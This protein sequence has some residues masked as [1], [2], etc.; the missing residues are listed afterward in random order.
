MSDSL[1]KRNRFLVAAV[2]LVLNALLLLTLPGGPTAQANAAPDLNVTLSDSP[3]P[4]AP[5]GIVTFLLS[6]SN[7]GNAAASGTVYMV[8]HLPPG[9]S[10]LGETFAVGAGWTCDMVMHWETDAFQAGSHEAL[11]CTRSGMAIGAAPTVSFGAT[12]QAGV[13]TSNNIV[14]ID[15][16]IATEGTHAESNEDADDPIEACS[17]EDSNP[18]SQEPDNYDC[19]PNT[20][21]TDLPNLELTQSGSSSSIPTGGTLTYTLPSRNVGTGTASGY[22]IDDFVSAGSTITAFTATDGADC[23]QISPGFSESPPWV[24]P[25]TILSGLFT[26]PAGCTD[27]VTLT[28]TVTAGPGAILNGALTDSTGVV[29]EANE[30]ADDPDLVCTTVGE[31]SDTAP[32]IEPDN[33]DCLQITV[34]AGY[35]WGDVDCVGDVDAV[36]ALKILRYVAGLS[37]SQTQPCP[38][39]GSEVASLLGDVDCDDDVDAIDSLKILRHVAALPVAQTEP[40]QDIGSSLSP[41]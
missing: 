39:I 21:S 23:D 3:D 10:F 17:G 24:G 31:G 40:C 33:Y 34:T 20:V 28:A 35:L 30:D 5:G 14:V 12:A 11:E 27:T 6:P 1:R 25:A 37:V 15:P 4:V 18:P 22:F 9:Y 19:E 16:D 7:D 38:E 32:G 29:T 26:T 8:D 36:D 13:G 41:G 2:P